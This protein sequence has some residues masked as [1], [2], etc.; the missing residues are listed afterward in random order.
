MPGSSRQQ[1]AA[2]T[3]AE[4][5]VQVRPPGSILKDLQVRRVGLADIADLITRN[6]YLHSVPAAASLAFGVFL[7]NRLVGAVIL[8]PGGRNAYRVLSGARPADVVTLARLWLA[9]EI[10][11]NA[12][13]RVLGIILRDL[14][15]DGRYKAVVSYADPGA[16]HAGIVYRASGWT[17]LGLTADERYVVLADGRTHNSR[18]VSSKYGSNDI[19]HLRRTG[20]PAKRVVVPGKHRFLYVLDPAWR[21]RVRDATT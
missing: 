13:S 17:Y 18:S 12:E 14:R 2:D 20:I 8:T 10:P 15:R 19:A 4:R 16:G 1:D 3:T 6:H 7:D 5:A 9:D 11:R 21:W